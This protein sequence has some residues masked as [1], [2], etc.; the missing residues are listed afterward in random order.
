MST[1]KKSAKR[2]PEPYTVGNLIDMLEM[3]DRDTPVVIFNSR[4]EYEAPT[5]TVVMQAGK[6][7]GIDFDKQSTVLLS[8]ES[9]E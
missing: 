6:D 4:G 3:Q 7:G 1:K 2:D 8:A 9:D 5:I